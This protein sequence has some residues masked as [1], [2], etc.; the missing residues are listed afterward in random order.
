MLG[1]GFHTYMPD[2]HQVRGKLK[3]IMTWF[4]KDLDMIWVDGIGLH[5]RKKLQEYFYLNLINPQKNFERCS[6]QS[7]NLGDGKM[8][9]N[10]RSC[11][12]NLGPV[13]S[14]LESSVTLLY[15]M[16]S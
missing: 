11:L 3:N 1:P 4:M 13:Q 10:G 5:I 12:R 15:F 6:W 14:T 9:A 2:C 16:N 8:I 7:P